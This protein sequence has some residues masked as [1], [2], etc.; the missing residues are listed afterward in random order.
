MIGNA[1]HALNVLLAALPLPR[2]HIKFL[3]CKGAKANCEPW[4]RSFSCKIASESYGQFCVEGEEISCIKSTP[5]S[6]LPPS[7]LTLVTY[8]Q[9][10]TEDYISS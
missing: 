7:D 10:I 2:F 1:R 6:T 5:N 9:T 4:L 8:L 3:R